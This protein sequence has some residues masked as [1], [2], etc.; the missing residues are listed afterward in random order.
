MSKK[1]YRCRKRIFEIIEVGTDLDRVSR[2]YDFVNAFTIVLNL[3]VCIMYTF[4]SMEE[5][6]GDTLLAIEEAT[7]AFFCIDYILRICTAK[8]L[9][10]EETEGRAIRKYLFSFVGMIDMLSV[11]PY[12]LPIFFPAG[13]VAFRMIRIIRIFRLFRLNAYYDSFSVIVEVIYGKRQ[14]LVSSVFI[15]LILMISASLCMYSLENEAQPDVFTNAFPESGGQHLRCL[16]LVMVTFIRLRH[17]ERCLVF[18]SPFWVSVWLRFLP[19][20]FPL[21]LLICTLIS[22]EEMNMDTK[23][24]CSLSRFTSQRMTSGLTSALQNCHYLPV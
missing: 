9:Y 18:L 23:R 21:D 24:I 8:F 15:I 5:K 13:T 22:R 6:Y 14:Q 20:L 2:I 7:V 12:Y 19:V 11:V 16:L 4:S 3:V 17:G 1:W 10:P